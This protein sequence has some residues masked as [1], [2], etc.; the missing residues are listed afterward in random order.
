MLASDIISEMEDAR[1]K[2]MT[3]A[4]QEVND[5]LAEVHHQIQVCSDE[6]YIVCVEYKRAMVA[7]EQALMFIK[8][9][10]V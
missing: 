3:K 1:R 7:I 6:S 8:E 9:I 2:I 10:T 4:M 5:Q